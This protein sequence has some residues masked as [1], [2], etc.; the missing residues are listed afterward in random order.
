MFLL[1]YAAKIMRRPRCEYGLPTAQI[2][3]QPKIVAFLAVLKYFC[4]QVRFNP[5]WRVLT[6]GKKYDFYVALGTYE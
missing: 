2:I 3:Y 4:V 1:L 6:I 5:I